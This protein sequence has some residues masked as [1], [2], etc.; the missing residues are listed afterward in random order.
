MLV[1]LILVIRGLT[2]EMRMSKVVKPEFSYFVNVKDISSRGKHFK[3]TATQ[4]ECDGL[5]KRFELESLN[6]L[7]ASLE[8]KDEG[9]SH[10][11]TLIGKLSAV[12]QQG[13]GIGG[14]IQDVFVDETIN[15][16]FLPEDKI[17]PELEE[18]NLMT[19]DSEDLE[20]LPEETIDLGELMSQYLGL[21]VDPYFGDDYI[22]S[23][24]DIGKGVS[25]NEP[26]LERPNPFAVL[27]GLKDKLQKD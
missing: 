12:A 9:K 20:Q 1:L 14:D 7:H 15:I 10:G 18:E 19:L 5:A 26:A 25:F 8:M 27:S 16:R 23:K 6:E 17:T 24:E 3:L 13:V 21:S 11:I 4:E 22:L 2:K